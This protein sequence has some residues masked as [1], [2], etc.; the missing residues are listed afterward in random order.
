[1]RQTVLIKC[2]V[3]GIAFLA[4]FASF[5]VTPQVILAASLQAAPGTGVY[6]INTTFTVRV[7]VNSDG[8]SINAA[9]GTLKFNP[10]ELSVVSVNRSTSVF[11]LWVTEPTFSNSA[12]T[13]TFSGG[14][15]TGYTGNGGTVFTVTFK[16]LTAGT[17]KLTFTNGA[18]LANDGRGTNVLSAMNGGTYTISAVANEPAAEVIEYV[19]PANTPAQPKITST[20]HP[21][22]ALWYANSTAELSWSVPGDVVA[23][24]TLLD[25]SP[26]SVPTKLYDAPIRTITLPDLEEGVSY[27]HLQFEN[28]DGWGKVA[29]YRLG[30]D[31]VKPET[32]TV[33]LAPESDLSNPVQT[34]QIATKE[35]TSPVT[36]YMVRIDD[37]EAV[38]YL[39]EKSTGLITMPSL[40]PG[41]HSVIVEA[42]DAAGNGQ[43]GTFSFTLEAFERPVFTEYPEEINEQVI[44]VIRGTSR[45]NAT[46]AVTV[47]RLGAD[48]TPYT[49]SADESGNFTFIPEGRFTEGVYEIVAV[50]T[51]EHGAVSLPSDAIRIAVQRPGYLQIGSFIVSILSVLVPLVGLLVLLVLL[52]S[53]LLLYT[54]RFKRQVSRESHEV[55]AILGREFETLEA[56]LRA[57]E[58]R[59]TEAKRTKKLSP[60]EEQVFARLQTNLRDARTRVQ[61]EVEDVESLVQ[62]K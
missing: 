53:T 28:E 48:S 35:S 21:D 31:T 62:E 13:V 54:R 34:L 18:V 33:S 10:A 45:K 17:S 1:M 5:L 23:M 40:T 11:N 3:L 61:K 25:R 4:C 19:A 49:V 52:S 16:A 47:T 2:R 46:V 14:S 37:A 38:E 59:L 8:Q 44:P 9:E 60:L 24:R 43:L 6:Q 22:S 29:H 51:D 41:Y 26:S 15:P 57:E 20:T 27:F 36:R 42:F 7:A 50:A 39:D 32:V 30:V 56:N 55:L 12:G 58:E